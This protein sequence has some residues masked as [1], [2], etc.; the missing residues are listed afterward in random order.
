MFNVKMF[1][2]RLKAAR[3]AKHISQADLAKAV[4]VSAA[5]ISSYETVNGAKIPSLDKAEAIA[6]KLDVSL[7]WLCGKDS[8]GKVKITDFDTETF[9]RSLVVVLSEMTME[10]KKSDSKPAIYID[11][12]KIDKYISQVQDI[13]RVYH[14]GSLSTE[15]FEA[16]IDRMILNYNG[17]TIFGSRFLSGFELESAYSSLEKQIQDYGLSSIKLGIVSVA[18]FPGCILPADFNIFASEKTLEECKEIAEKTQ[19]GEL[20]GSNNPKKE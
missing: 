2:E 6:D 16:C 8:A 10:Y 18:L 9:L 5:T 13:L 20:D 11:N 17:Y 4:G 7:D 12:S 19:G 14:N 3:T 1:S 15:L